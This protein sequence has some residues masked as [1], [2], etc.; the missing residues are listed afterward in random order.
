MPALTSSAAPDPGGQPRPTGLLNIN[1]IATALRIS[2]MTVYRF[3][4]DDR[5]PAIRVGKSLRVQRSDLE[6]FLRDHSDYR[7]ERLADR[8]RPEPSRSRDIITGQAAGTDHNTTTV[9]VGIDGSAGSQRALRFAVREA[10]LRGA[11]LRAVMAL[12]PTRARGGVWS[13]TTDK[14]A[15]EQSTRA[16]LD[17]VIDS[18][19]RETDGVKIDRVLIFGEPAQI[20]MEEAQRADLLVVGVPRHRDRVRPLLDSV[21]YQCAQHAPCPVAVVPAVVPAR[22]RT[23][24]RQPRLSTAQ[25]AELQRMHATGDYTITDLAELFS[26]SR[27][28]V[29]RS[30]RAATPT[31]FDTPGAD[32]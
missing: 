10:R 13:P 11:I 21:T 30:L 15:L 17:T 22:A 6:A 14:T 23:R 19:G 5:L 32:P 29:Y 9:V 2:K 16:A 4:H 20:L 25:Q 7:D 3:I 1:E 26:V 31:A 28:T 12:D 24:G 8:V 18:M 27:P